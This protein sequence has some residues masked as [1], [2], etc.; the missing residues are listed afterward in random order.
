MNS[1]AV[2]S[3]N[4]QTGEKENPA[5][6]N[7]KKE[8]CDADHKQGDTEHPVNDGPDPRPAVSGRTKYQFCRLVHPA[9]SVPGRPNAAGLNSPRKVTL[10]SPASVTDS[11]CSGFPRSLTDNLAPLQVRI[12]TS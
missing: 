8:P 7:R 4:G 6:K 1:A 11:G 9:P 10:A 5:L 3:E 2:I 12:V